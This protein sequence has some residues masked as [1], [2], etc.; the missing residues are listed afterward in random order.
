MMNLDA[1]LEPVKPERFEPA[2]GFAPDQW[3][4]LVDMYFREGQFPVEIDGRC[5]LIGLID[6]AGE[7]FPA[8]AIRHYLYQL[9][10]DVYAKAFCDLGDYRF[11]LKRA[12]NYESLA[13]LLTEVQAQG[14]VPLL[15]G[16]GA[17]YT[18]AQYLAYEYR[19]Q[20]VNL[21]QVAPRFRIDLKAGAKVDDVNYLAPMLLREPNYL[22][23]FSQ[24]GYQSYFMNREHLELMEQLYFEGIRLGDIRADLKLAEPV[25]RQANL[26]SIDLGAVRYADYQ[27]SDAASPNG[28]AGEEIC[29][30]ARYAGLNGTLHAAGFYNYHPPKDPHGQCAHLIAHAIWYLVEGMLY[31]RH[32]FPYDNLAQYMRYHVRMENEQETMV[33][34]KSKFSGR[35]WVEVPIEKLRAEDRPHQLIP[36]TYEDYLQAVEHQIPDRYWKALMKLS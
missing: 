35:W 19:E 36:C 4:S 31:N 7:G 16:R 24:L 20:Y 27:A 32:E 11:P 21:V 26:L 18:Y 2:G 29:A 23:N 6:D 22:F 30:L 33:F 14:G 17:H 1:V 5:C 28:F 34:Y 9:R 25:M 8:D 10:N 12:S 3:G 15:L 13:V